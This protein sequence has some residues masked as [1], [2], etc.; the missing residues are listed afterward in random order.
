MGG[1]QIEHPFKERPIV[2]EQ[3][4][5]EVFETLHKGAYRALDFGT[6]ARIYEVLETAVDGDLLETIYLQL[7]ESLAM[8]EQGGAVARVRA[9]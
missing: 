5:R 2:A 9:V 4:A 7:R 3:E 6:E 8:L 1:P